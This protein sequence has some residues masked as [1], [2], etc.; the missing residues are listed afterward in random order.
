[1]REDPTQD[2]GDDQQ[3]IHNHYDSK[4]I[5]VFGRFINNILPIAVVALVAAVWNL[6]ISVAKLQVTVD[7]LTAE[8]ARMS[9]QK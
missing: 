1:M 4:D 9:I 5:G 3:V 2:Y 7:G 6:S 8:V